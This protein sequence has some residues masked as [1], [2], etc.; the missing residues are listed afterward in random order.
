LTYRCNAFHVQES[1]IVS[2]LGCGEGDFLNECVRS[3]G[4]RGIGTCFWGD[5]LFCFI[6]ILNIIIL[7]TIKYATT[8]GFV[9][10]FFLLGIDMNE[11][12]LANARRSAINM[13]T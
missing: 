12:I 4:A 6:I 10:E 8:V 9:L 5:T 1:D 13:G 7:L 11:D 3:T 2:D